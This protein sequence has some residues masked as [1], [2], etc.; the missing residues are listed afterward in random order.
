MGKILIEI[1]KS[2]FL[3]IVVYG[4][5]VMDF[6]LKVFYLCIM[7]DCFLERIEI[8]KG[9]RNGKRIEIYIKIIMNFV[10]NEIVVDILIR[11]VIVN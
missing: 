6:W 7:V 1:I 4:V 11:S 3:K 5:I 9:V 8:R 10:V 2:V